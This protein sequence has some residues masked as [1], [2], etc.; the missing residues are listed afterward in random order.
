[1][2]K[3]STTERPSYGLRKNIEEVKKEV[4]LQQY[5]HDQGV[6]VRHNRTRCPVHGGDNP[7][8]FSIV[9]ESQRWHCFRCGESGDLI[10]L[11]QAVEGGEN[12]EAMVALA[13]RY[14]VERSE[15]SSSWLEWQDD[16][17]RVRDA[18][19]KHL[20]D[21]YIRRLLRIYA[22]LVLVGGETPGEEVEELERLASVLWPFA[23]RLAGKR[24]CDEG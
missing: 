6:E 10:D 7:Q 13:E 3:E 8:S 21:V 24:V 22:P 20:A 11:C 2:L 1:M 23:L 4:T 15:R 18:M 9:P 17:Y 14:G 16:K 5:L 12:W 19:H